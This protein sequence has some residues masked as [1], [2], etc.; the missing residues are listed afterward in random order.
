M[1]D[2]LCVYIWGVVCC[3]VAGFDTLQ[4]EDLMATVIIALLWFI[5]VPASLFKLILRGKC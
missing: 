5:V 2:L 3:L 1:S 4:W